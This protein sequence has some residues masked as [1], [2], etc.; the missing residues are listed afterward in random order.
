MADDLDELIAA[1]IV[2]LATAR[3]SKKSI[4]PSDAARAVSAAHS[5]IDWRQLM[6][7]VHAVVERLAASGQ[8]VILQLGVDQGTHVPRGVYRVRIPGDGGS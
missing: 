3:G 8:I 7:R 6:P 5:A 1:A 2:R 4:C